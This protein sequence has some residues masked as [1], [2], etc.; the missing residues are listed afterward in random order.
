MSLF[1]KH[2]GADH[3]DLALALERRAQRIGQMGR[4]DEAAG[5]TARAAKA[6]AKKRP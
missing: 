1:E 4:V 6:R 3:P 2:L 5:L